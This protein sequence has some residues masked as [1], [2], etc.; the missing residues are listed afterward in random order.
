MKLRS[1]ISIEQAPRHS[2]PAMEPVQSAPLTDS[3]I[4]LARV[5]HIDSLIEDLDYARSI[6]VKQRDFF[7]KAADIKREIDQYRDAMAK[8]SVTPT[9]S[10]GLVEVKNEHEIYA[11]AC[12]EWVKCILAYNNDCDELTDT[13]QYGLLAQIDGYL[14]QSDDRQMHSVFTGP[15]HGLET[16]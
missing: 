1:D 9:Q 13:L 10:I 8:D 16:V 2:F 15:E 6:A 5:R 14:W 11:D 12:Q 3:E 4:L 7:A